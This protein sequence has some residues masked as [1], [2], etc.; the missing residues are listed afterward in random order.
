MGVTGGLICHTPSRK[1]LFGGRAVRVFVMAT[2]LGGLLFLLAGTAWTGAAP[3]PRHIPRDLPLYL[4]TTIGTRWVYQTTD[5]TPKGIKRESETTYFLTDVDWDKSTARI[6]IHR[7]TSHGH[8][9]P[10]WQYIASPNGLVLVGFI[11]DVWHD[12]P[13][14]EIPW[15]DGLTLIGS[16]FLPTEAPLPLLRLPPSPAMSWTYI[17]GIWEV[18]RTIHGWERV[19]VPAGTYDA[20]RVDCL[21]RPRRDGPSTRT[22]TDWYAPKVGL[23]KYE[24]LGTCWELKQIGVKFE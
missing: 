21:Y 8:L 18:T 14:R 9:Y 23:V 12:L 15:G 7:L 5:E 16:P 1:Q 3:V 11:D 10:H 4:P 24:S 22:G 6:S 2:L 13:P 20:V 17:D 19:E